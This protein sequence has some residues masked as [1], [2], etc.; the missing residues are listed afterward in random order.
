MQE[1]TDKE[2]ITELEVENRR[3]KAYEDSVNEIQL[4][5]YELKYLLENERNVSVFARM[6]FV[7]KKLFL[8]FWEACYWLQCRPT[9]VGW[10]KSKVRPY[11]K[12][13]V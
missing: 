1:A 3:L 2:R 4:K 13:L 12:L 7:L 5:F 8:E 6:L 11:N 10:D 9:R